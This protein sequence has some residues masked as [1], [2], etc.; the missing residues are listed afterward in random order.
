MALTEVFVGAP[1]VSN[2]LWSFPTASTVRVPQ[3]AS[4]VFYVLIDVMANLVAGD[5]FTFTAWEKI[6]GAGATQ[7]IV[8]QAT[9]TGPPTQQLMFPP[10]PF[11]DGWDITAIRE[12]G[13]DRVIP[14]SIRTE[15]NVVTLA[16]SALTAAAAAV[17]S[18]VSEGA[19]TYGDAV[20]LIGSRLFGKATVQ[21]GDGAYTYR[22]KADTKNRIAMTRTGTARTVS[23]RDGT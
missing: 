1:T 7:R 16:G 21:D 17:W 22:D 10:L 6:N 12:A 3:T 8:H 23:T 2:T 5:R 13:A 20:R 19:E 18:A 15:D 4:G 9:I 14:F 11:K